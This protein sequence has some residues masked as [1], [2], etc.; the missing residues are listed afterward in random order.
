MQ[1]LPPQQLFATNSSSWEGFVPV[2]AQPAGPEGRQPLVGARSSSSAAS[3]LTRH[4]PLCPGLG[5]RR[6][7]RPSTAAP[8]AAA[9]QGSLPGLFLSPEGLLFS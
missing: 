1:K 3:V 4:L 2:P 8:G 6:C 5:S 7:C 9:G